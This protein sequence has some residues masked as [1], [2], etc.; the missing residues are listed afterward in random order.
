MSTGAC[1][2]VW[3]Y[4]PQGRATSNEYQVT[5][6]KHSSPL[7]ANGCITVTNALNKQTINRF[8]G[9]VGASQTL[10]PLLP[11]APPHYL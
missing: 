3:A 10:A 7:N 9:I 4:D 5:Q 6:K 1:Y 11:K 8:D 2:A